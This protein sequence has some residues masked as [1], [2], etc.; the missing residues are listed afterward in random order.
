MTTTT[1]AAISPGL[2]AILDALTDDT[3]R[4]VSRARTL[5]DRLAD[6]LADLHEANADDEGDSPL[7]NAAD[8]ATELASILDD[9]AERLHRPSPRQAETLL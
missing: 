8:T 6:D 7:S 3:G 4:L 9:L 2:A 1:P 5:A